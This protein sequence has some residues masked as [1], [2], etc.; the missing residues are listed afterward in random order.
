MNRPSVPQNS[1]VDN[2]R[3]SRAVQLPRK[4]RMNSAPVAS[5]IGQ[6]IVQLRKTCGM[7]RSELARRSGV[8]RGSLSVIERSRGI[9]GLRTLLPIFRALYGRAFI[10]ADVG[11]VGR[12]VRLLRE[13]YLLTCPEFASLIAC[14][15]QQVSNWQRGAALPCLAALRRMCAAFG[16]GLD[17]F[18]WR[19]ELMN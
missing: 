13:A 5:A 1:E 16:V 19:T 8:D 4:A 3:S 10:I 2:S 17:F 15:K 7:S 14:N 6:H 11:E 9:P 18:S 12:R